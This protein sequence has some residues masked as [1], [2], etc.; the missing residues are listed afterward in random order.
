M[1]ITPELLRNFHSQKCSIL[2]VAHHGSADFY[3]E[4]YEE[5]GFDLAM[6]SVGKGNGYGHPTKRA[7]ET[8]E[9]AGVTAARTDEHGW[10]TAR[11]DQ[12][13]SNPSVKTLTVAGQR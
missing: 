6:V 13:G 3:Q 5:L 7:L 10:V 12:S 2:K 1:R 9:R 11:C 4:L 8:L